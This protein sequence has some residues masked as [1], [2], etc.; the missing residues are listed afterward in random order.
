MDVHYKIRYLIPTDLVDVHYNVL[1]AILYSHGMY[2]TMCNT[3]MYTSTLQFV[4]VYERVT[5]E[6][7]SSGVW[8]FWRFSTEF[9]RN[10]VSRIFQ[11]GE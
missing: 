6:R 10:F 8:L 5:S 4:Q 11:I 3:T 1:N 2:T 7:V 9:V